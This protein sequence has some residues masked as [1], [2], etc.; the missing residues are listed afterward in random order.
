MPLHM[1]RKDPGWEAG[2][3]MEFLAAARSPAQ[4]LQLPLFPE[5]LGGDCDFFP[6]TPACLVFKFWVLCSGLTPDYSQGLYLEGLR[7]SVPR[8]KPGSSL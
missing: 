5:T 7:K 2:L 1:L 6:H 3:V 4:H 8:I